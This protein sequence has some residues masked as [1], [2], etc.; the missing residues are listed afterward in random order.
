M[1]RT[2]WKFLIALFVVVTFATSGFVFSRP[3]KPSELPKP[4][5][6]HFPN[7]GPRP[8]GVRIYPSGFQT[9]EFF[10]NAYTKAKPLTD[11][12][13]LTA[14][15][16]QAR[17]ASAIVAHHLLVADKIAAVFQTI[18]SDDTDLVILI[19]P[20]HFSQGRARIQTGSGAWETPYGYVRADQPSIVK[21]RKNIS[22]IGLED[23]TFVREHGIAALTP[24][25]RRSFPNARI[26]PIVL[27]DS[28]TRD[29]SMKLGETLADLF[30]RAVVI[31]SID[32]S[33]YQPEHVQIFH[34]AVTEHA[35]AAGAGP[36][37]EIDSNPSLIALQSLNK[38]RSSE[39]WVETH[40][41]SSIQMGAAKNPEDNTSH[42]LGYFLPGKPDPAPFASFHFVGDI[43]LDRGVRRVIEKNDVTYPWENLDR[44]LSGVHLRVGNL[45]GTVSDRPSIA[46]DND[47][48]RFSMQSEAVKVAAN[49]LDVVSLANNHSMDF[50]GAGEKESHEWFEKFGLPWFGRWQT[51]D[52]RFDTDVGGLPVAIIGYHQFKPDENELVTQIKEAKEQGRFVIVFPH[53][54]TEYILTP[55]RSQERLAQKMADAGADLILGAHPHVVQTIDSF[56]TSRT[57]QTFQTP[58][59]YS[60]GNFI[61]D[62]YNPETW[63]GLTVG[64][65]LTEK[66]VTLYLMPV[67]AKFGQP[68]PMNDTDAQAMLAAMADRSPPELRDMIRLGIL[69]FPRK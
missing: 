28:T 22:T 17:P 66:A 15:T 19:S 26:L 62:Q 38:S 61:F 33:H 47:V 50:G 40:H 16:D 49:Y 35:I 20:N 3:P 68:E 14:L 39:L 53:W 52:P 44:F 4:S 51:P 12:T 32:M 65:I 67:W 6:F 58:V 54:G 55:D 7:S 21:L 64:V 46:T 29:E 42:I 9:R 43:M 59:V 18:G 2:H 56:P 10:D 41:G 37:L 11:L 69:T 31:A 45:E 48:L 27:D 60:M 30:P 23:D 8:P 5:T 63:K 57:S 24:F 34:D 13:T 36:T 25:I 1:Y